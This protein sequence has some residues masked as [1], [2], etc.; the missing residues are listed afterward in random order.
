MAKLAEAGYPK[1]W[2]ESAMYGDTS[3]SD[4]NVCPRCMSKLSS[5]LGQPASS[6]ERFV[7]EPTTTVLTTTEKL[8]I[9]TT[10]PN[11][12]AWWQFWK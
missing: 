11:K 6:G 4:W 9:T 1:R 12:K 8:P 7:S 2:A 5:Y 3:N 10:K